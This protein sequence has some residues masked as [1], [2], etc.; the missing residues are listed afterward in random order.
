MV[1]DDEQ[2]AL[3]AAYFETFGEPKCCTLSEA[4]LRFHAAVGLTRDMIAWQDAHPGSNKYEQKYFYPR[5][6]KSRARRYG[7]AACGIFIEHQCGNPSC[8]CCRCFE[9]PEFCVS[10]IPACVAA[11]LAEEP[12]REWCAGLPTFQVPRIVAG[13]ACP[14]SWSTCESVAL[15]VIIDAKGRVLE[16]TAAAALGLCALLDAEFPGDAPHVARSLV[17]PKAETGG[18]TS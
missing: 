11:R 17:G 1:T 5:T 10:C 8:S 12:V 16:S 3:D 15:V 18:T 14:S 13:P 7:Y 9:V 4:I 2:R 6:T